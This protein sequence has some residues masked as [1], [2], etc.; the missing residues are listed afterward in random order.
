MR[1]EGRRGLAPVLRLYLELC[2]LCFTT[3][4][5]LEPFLLSIKMIVLCVWT[6]L[7]IFFSMFRKYIN[8]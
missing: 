4:L 8:K 3:F 1:G 5:G 2:S 7:D 6:L